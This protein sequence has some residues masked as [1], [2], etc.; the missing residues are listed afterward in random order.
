M[1][2]RGFD[3]RGERQQECKNGY[4]L[5][6]DRCRGGC[7]GYERAYARLSGEIHP[8]EKPEEFQRLYKAYQKALRYVSYRK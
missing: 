4:R 5:L 2:Q 1:L 6:T 8:E 3:S 7:K